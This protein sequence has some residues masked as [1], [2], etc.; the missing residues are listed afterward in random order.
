M[1]NPQSSSVGKVSGTDGHVV[2]LKDLVNMHL[3]GSTGDGGGLPG[4]VVYGSK[5]LVATCR[6][7]VF[8]IFQC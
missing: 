6:V 7:G 8:Q 4:C 2:T 1:D 5:L 3:V